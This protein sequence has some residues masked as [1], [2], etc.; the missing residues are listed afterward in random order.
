MTIRTMASAGSAAV[1]TIGLAFGGE[2]P[3][4]EA[5]PD[6]ALDLTDEVTLEAWIRADPMPASGGRILDK[7][8]PGSSDGFLLDTWPGN[9]LRLITSNGQCRFDAKLSADRWT[10][11]AGVYGASGR[12]MKLFID[13]KE[14]VRVADGKFPAMTC[15]SLPLRIGADQNDENRFRGAIRRA[16]VYGRALAG[17]EIARRAADPDAAI[18]GA[19]GDWILEGET[20]STIRPVAGALVLRGPMRIEGAAPP[21]EEPLSLWYRRPARRWTEALVIG[22]GR[23]GGLVFG[24]IARE[25]V[26][27]N[28]DTLWSGEPRAYKNPAALASLAEVRKLL[29]DGKERA[30]HDLVARTYRGVYNQ[31][32]MPLGGIALAFEG[33]RDV[34]DYRRDLDLADGVAR[35][36]YRSGGATFTREVFATAPDR[37]IVIRLACDAP[38]RIDVAVSLESPLRAGTVAEKDQVILTGRAPVHADPHY[39]G[40][41]IRYD[42]AED[43]K[44]MRFQV[45]IRAMAEGGS[46][47]A[48]G[49]SLAVRGADAVTLVLA[50][51]TSFNG[52]DKSPSAQGKAYDSLCQ[53]DLHRASAKPY[54]A[55]LA[56]HV[57][58]HRRLFGRV[59]LD[60][61]EPSPLPTDERIRA[62]APG[63]DPGL[64]ALHVQ[65]GRYL[66]IAG[67]RPGTQPANLQGIW[68][69][70]L[71]PA[72]SANWTL[73]CNAQINY[74]GVEVFNLSECHEPLLDL[75]REIEVD[76]RAV[77]RE[78][79]GARG[80]MA[81]H[82]TD[83]WRAAA[84][85]DGNPLWFIFQTGGAWLCQH[86][87]E[88]YRF[89]GDEAFLR[90]AWP[91]IRDAARY[92][93]DAMIEEPRHGWLVDAPATNFES[94]FRKPN[95]E[96]AAVCMGPTADIQ[97]I[98]ELFRNAIE[99]SRVL[100]VDPAFRAEAERALARLAPMQVSPRTGHLQE[101][102]EDWDHAS[103]RNHQMLSLWGLICG[104]QITP[105]GTPE[106]AKAVRKTME[107][108]KIAVG[109][110]CS[111]R[112]AFG[113][114]A[115][116]RLGDGDR[117][118]G[119]IDQ[120]LGHSLNPNMTAHFHT[121][122]AAFEI[123]GN[124]GIA[125]A[126]AEM[127]LQSHAGEIE[128]LPALPK[129]WPS[130]R[131]SGLRA[132]GGFEVGI[133]WEDGRLVEAEIRS[134]RGGAARIRYGERTAEW[135]GE[136][137]E[138]LR[139][140]GALRPR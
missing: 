35:I 31:C 59:R 52:F 108:R 9:S 63:A 135:T 64:A 86:L 125:A 20:A 34:A 38:G 44:G 40:A 5:G 97:I 33:A 11:V 126:V 67:S 72:W 73:N 3:I 77:A 122:G 26:L 106:L 133:A 134:D 102:I 37:A 48:R 68:N 85:V 138:T 92:F 118:A 50:A 94:Y 51:A 47:A 2:P 4:Y 71:R 84:P 83:L 58:D 100:D 110:A 55:L 132:R 10:H 112:G 80:W 29:L 119:V 12:I 121:A 140:D 1:L 76:G 19:I 45:R 120:H 113:A 69:V 28:E 107:D 65:F 60:L 123:D 6:A 128:L 24:G 90:S 124:L 98:R 103:P 104:T 25:T 136:A 93:L 56:A 61:G 30:A 111:W 130:G 49:D 22:N 70:D 43:G 57:A 109:D 89:T 88:H 15:P 91:T 41:A 18:E 32:Y 75:V 78:M 17:E 114:N 8:P 129:A 39:A 21:P 27:L 117:A 13:G 66:L 23:L 127:L 42:D 95:G 53:A 36:R 46:V 137:G 82:N 62:Y 99:A 101:W 96:T 139:L 116:A 105:R 14:V 74:W 131:V 54:A 115:Y 16:A 79:Y 87:W 7:M 81:H